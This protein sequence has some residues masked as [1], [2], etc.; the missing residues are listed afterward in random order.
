MQEWLGANLNDSH[1]QMHK[2]KKR[3]K[4]VFDMNNAR[5]RDL[6]S[7]ARATGTI[8]DAEDLIEKS[9]VDPSAAEDAFIQSIDN[10]PE[11]LDAA[12]EAL[13]DKGKLR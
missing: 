10:D 11:M 13:K 2:S 3:R 7:Y 12:I 8:A 6:L 9:V 4:Q 1:K 5:N